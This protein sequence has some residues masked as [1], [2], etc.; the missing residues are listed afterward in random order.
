MTDS[1]F[2][3]LV[4]AR[5]REA[6]LPAPALQHEVVVAGKTYRIDLAYPEA[7]VAIE[8]DGSVHLRRDVWEADHGRQNALVL[9]GWTV[10]RFTWRDYLD[11][12]ADLV[13]HVAAALRAAA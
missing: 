7:R 4:V 12:P 2:E 13:R 5:L 1:G 6:G 9:A 10:L 8:L 3:R 11:R